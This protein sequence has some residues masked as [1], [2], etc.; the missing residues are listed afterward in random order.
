MVS[1]ESKVAGREANEVQAGRP[2]RKA[3][4]WDSAHWVLQSGL[5]GVRNWADDVG[6]ACCWVEAEE[7]QALQWALGHPRGP[8]K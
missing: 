6:S 8:R 3:T 7:G 4:C 2:V 1:V 5:G